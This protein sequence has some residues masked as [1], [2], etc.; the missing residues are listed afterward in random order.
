MIC[1]EEVGTHSLIGDGF[2][3]QIRHMSTSLGP[4][5]SIEIFEQQ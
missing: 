5:I 4:I 1:A 2:L 3:G